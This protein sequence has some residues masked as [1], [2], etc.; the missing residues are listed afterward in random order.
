VYGGL[1]ALRDLPGGGRAEDTA[2][3]VRSFLLQYTVNGRFRKHAGTQSVDASLLWLCLP[4][5]VLE[6]SHPLMAE[7]A[8]EIERT[9]LRRGG[10][11]RY[12]EDTYY[13]GGRWLILSAWLGWYYVRVGRTA[14]ARAQLDW[15]G[16]Q[17]DADGSLPEQVSTDVNDPSMI[18]P[19]V[20]RWGRVAR[21]LVWSHAMYL[22]LSNELATA[23]DAIAPFPR[24]ES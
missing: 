8:R 22:V 19:W 23:G 15:V 18:A 12:R 13:G 5:G 4:F 21:P 17:A 7:T 10:V 11:C 20:K 1:H 24:E 3:R 14:E 9:L 2:A 6:P 16:A